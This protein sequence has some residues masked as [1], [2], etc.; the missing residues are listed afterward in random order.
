MSV[1]E[2]LASTPVTEG[3]TGGDGEQGNEHHHTAR[4][5]NSPPLF[6]FSL[7]ELQP[8]QVTELTT[9]PNV[10]WYATATCKRKACFSVCLVSTESNI[11]FY[12]YF[13]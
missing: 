11:C 2:R 5:H 8:F 3:D 7:L 10:A 13:F 12:F 1:T 6:L 9:L 4:D